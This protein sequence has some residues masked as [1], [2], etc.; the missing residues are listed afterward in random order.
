MEDRRALGYGAARGVSEA[1]VIDVVE[2]I[3]VIQATPMRVPRPSHLVHLDDLDDIDYLSFTRVQAFF[4]NVSR[5]G[6]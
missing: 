5:S 4:R 2:G 6:A 1:E 3:E